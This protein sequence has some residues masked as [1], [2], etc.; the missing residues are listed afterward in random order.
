MPTLQPVAA[1]PASLGARPG[2]VLERID[3][4]P[5]LMI[6]RLARPP[7][8]SFVPGQSVRVGVRDVSHPYTIASGPEAPYLEL[9]V[10]LVPNGQLTPLLFQLRPGDVVRLGSSAKGDLTLDESVTDHLMFATVTGVAP[11]IS[12]WRHELAASRARRRFLLVHGASRADELVYRDALEQLARALPNAAYVPA[13]S[14]PDDPANRG[15]TGERGRLPSIAGRWVAR[16]ELVPGSCRVYA[17][18]NPAMVAAI[19]AQL[20]APGVPVSTESFWRV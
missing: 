15:W 11:F 6:L 19:A 18:G 1:P 5:D 7:G 3:V 17:C 4:T 14:R 9:C 10:E 16:F 12:I 13:I 20:E 2:T 8:F